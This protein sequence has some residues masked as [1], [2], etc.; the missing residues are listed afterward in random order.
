MAET[1]EMHDGFVEDDPTQWRNLCSGSWRRISV[2]CLCGFWRRWWNRRRKNIGR[3]CEWVFLWREKDLGV[4]NERESMVSELVSWCAW[5]L[6]RCVCGWIWGQC[7]RQVSVVRY[8]VFTE[9]VS[10]CVKV[11]LCISGVL[12]VREFFSV[13]VNLRVLVCASPVEDTE[14]REC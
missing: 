6:V 8:G 7:V 11:F 14:K 5:V 9:G 10:V 3:L 4:G 1:E 12:R 13:C 2:F